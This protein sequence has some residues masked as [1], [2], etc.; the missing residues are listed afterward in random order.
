MSRLE[1]SAA[2]TD[3]AMAGVAPELACQLAAIIAQIVDARMQRGD[4]D[5]LAA[6][7][8]RDFTTRRARERLIITMLEQS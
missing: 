3:I 8:L 6:W 1:T 4:P 7:L 2:I 5:R